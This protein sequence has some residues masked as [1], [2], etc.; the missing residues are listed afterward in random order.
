VLNL[1]RSVV[2]EPEQGLLRTRLLAAAILTEL[3]P[4]PH[5]IV[6]DFDLPV[7]LKYVPIIMPAFLAQVCM[8][9]IYC[10]SSLWHRGTL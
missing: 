2:L 1:L 3:C 5:I 4:N 9:D 6:R 7:E 10:M 8:E